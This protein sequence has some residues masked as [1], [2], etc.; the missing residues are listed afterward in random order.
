MFRTCILVAVAACSQTPSSKSVQQ[1]PLDRAS[2]TVPTVSPRLEYAAVATRMLA[3]VR[4]L[5]PA[6][7]SASI[8]WT[9]VYVDVMSS[10]VNAR[11]RESLL[12]I[13]QSL[14]H[15]I[16]PTGSV[17]VGRS[18]T[19]VPQRPDGATTLVR[20]HHFGLGPSRPYHSFR[21]GLDSEKDFELT[22]SAVAGI[23]RLSRCGTVEVSIRAL[24]T[25]ETVAASVYLVP[26]G[27]SELKAEQ[28]VSETGK[29]I[30][31]RA[32]IPVDT[33]Y[34][35]VGVVAKGRSRVELLSARGRCDGGEAFSLDLKPET[36]VPMG[37]RDLYSVGQ[38]RCAG[39]PC[40]VVERYPVENVFEPSHDVL[41]MD[42]GEGL[43]LNLPTA[44]WSDGKRTLPL[45]SKDGSRRTPSST[46]ATDLAVRLAAV[47]MT[48]GTLA[49]F[50]PY[51]TELGI[52]WGQS[53]SACITRCSQRY[54][55]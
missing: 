46:G 10:V 53:S 39:A 31:L 47:G 27:H 52:D 6:D 15:E 28:A 21:E 11:D 41:D 17:S 18:G 3:A 34:L 26:A 48:W 19:Q 33:E 14:A 40:L 13:L 44:V 29:E 30:T 12:A 7:E 50:Y 42:L 9:A 49:F 55:P 23:R 45:V 22:L 54:Q 8:D 25:S 37:S 51:F 16:A 4:Y 20:W 35:E 38:A 5:H 36:W 43:H 1:D 2:H 32:K 24:Q